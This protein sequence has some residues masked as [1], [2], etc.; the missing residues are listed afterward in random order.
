MVSV[1]GTS[2][3]TPGIGSKA[4]IGLSGL[5]AIAFVVLA[6]LPYRA[7]LGSQEAARQSLQDLQF[8]LMRRA[9]GC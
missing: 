5:A 2:T 1:E 6:A 9:R 4:L 7:M 8:A 3:D